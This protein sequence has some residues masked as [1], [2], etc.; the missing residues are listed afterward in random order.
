[1][2][3]VFSMALDAN[4]DPAVAYLITDPDNNDDAADTTL[5][6]VA[7]NRAAYAW[8]PPVTIAVV[9]V[10]DWNLRGGLSL[11]FDATTTR[12]G[13]SHMAGDSELRLA[14]SEDGV[15]WRDVTVLKSDGVIGG[16]SLALDRG[17][18]YLANQEPGDEGR[19][20]L[21]FRSGLQTDPPEKWKASRAPL[22]P[23][24]YDATRRG[25][26][27]AVDGAGK[28]A[29]AYWLNPSDDYT[30]TLAFWRPGDPS[31]V[32]ISD[33]ADHQMDGPDAN[34][35]F[36][37][38]EPSVVFYARRDDKFYDGDHQLWTSRSPDGGA[39]WPAPTPMPEDGGNSMGAPVHIA[40]S[41]AGRTVITAPV[42]GGN[43]GGTR[44]G[45]PKLIQSVDGKAWTICSAESATGTPTRDAR[46]PMPAFAGNDKL[47]VVF[48][49]DEAPGSFKT[50]L[51]LWRER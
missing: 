28:P 44:C 33:T 11:A 37:D 16:V 50:G 24:T 20:A 36:R 42:D 34:L 46:L 1:M 31:A 5:W 26:S 12:F 7:W 9:G 49:T 32:K 19:G 18:V 14:F 39:S 21:R 13:L 41:R 25:L 6:F 38:R 10:S 4:D 27:V 43:N 45:Q 30:W 40:V 35:T 29:V 3:R 48:K 22:L 17:Q 15:A 47:Y 8:K 51:I 23:R 2:A